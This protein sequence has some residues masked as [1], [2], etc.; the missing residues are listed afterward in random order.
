[1]G[2]FIQT[3]EGEQQHCISHL[4]QFLLLSLKTQGGVSNKD[5]IL[6]KV[7]FKLTRKALI[8]KWGKDK[9]IKTIKAS[10]ELFVTAWAG[11]LA[12]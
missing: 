12:L 3:L 7:N 4:S 5:R 6:A 11:S 9:V 1:M 8:L 2:D 10:L